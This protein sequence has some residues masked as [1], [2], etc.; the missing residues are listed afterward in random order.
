MMH[1]KLGEAPTLPR[2][3]KSDR[4][5]VFLPT[6]LDQALQLKLRYPKAKVAAGYTELGM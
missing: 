1:H 2:S 5:E 6:T 3:Y 4:V